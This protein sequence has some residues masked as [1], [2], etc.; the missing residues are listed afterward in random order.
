MA[1][2]DITVRKRPPRLAPLW[3]LLAGA[4]LLN[5]VPHFVNGISGN[6][7]PTPFAD[8][9]GRGLSAPE[10]NVAWALV[11]LAAGYLLARVSVKKYRTPTNV[12]L[13]ILGGILISFMLS[14]AFA[15]KAA[16]INPG[17]SVRVR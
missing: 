15:D 7:F 13:F 6:T 10:T 1:K 5:A 12:A 14:M 17:N 16:G 3:S 2:S 11:N 9:P 4:L 8:P